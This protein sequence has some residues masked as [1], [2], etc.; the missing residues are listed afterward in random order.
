MMSA[1]LAILTIGVVSLREILPLLTE[2]IREDQI[3]YVNL[4]GKLSREEVKEEYEPADDEERIIALL[5]DDQLIE[6]S[7]AK[8]E[9]DIQA[10]IEVL[11]NQGF[12]VILLMSSAPLKGLVARNAILLEPQRMIPPLVSSIVHGH[13]MGVIVPV[14][15]L[16]KHQRSNWLKLQTPP[17][18]ALANPM[19]GTDDELISAARQLL[20]D[21]ADV[22]MLDS[23][24]FHLHHRDLLQ[25]VLDVPVLLSNVLLAR[26][27]VELLI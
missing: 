16:L 2:H 23:Q 9:R 7:K 19:H 27:T 17:C 20:D 1:T 12:D 15:E 22:L 6:V 8:I 26:L 5:N 11:D 3:T 25:K 24:G 10:V 21:G 4:L 13:Q 18:Y 14:P